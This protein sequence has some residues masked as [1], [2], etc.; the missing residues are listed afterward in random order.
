[1]LDSDHL[2]V[3]NFNEN[4][5][6][7]VLCRTNDK[8]AFIQKGLSK[9]IKKI[10]ADI[11]SVD[12]V[13]ISI[14]DASIIGSLLSMNSRGAVVCDFIDSDSTKTIEKQGLDLCIIDDKI[15]AAGNDILVNDNGCMVHP[16]LKDSTLKKIEKV[17]DVPVVRGTIGSL[18][19]VGMCAAVTNK[20]LLCHPKASAE[21]I[22]KLEKL[23]QVPV[24]I[25]TV[26]HGSPVIGSGVI[27]NVNG[28]VVGNKTTGIELG[29]IE[30]AFGFL[31]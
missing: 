21:E 15:N 2:Q 26:N 1:M 18:K 25:G 22:N 17:F 8:V 14:F 5:N 16:D 31:D 28:V 19:T 6:V 30:E 20:G 13:E 27:A 9:K 4:P 12:L 3:V 7:G 23:F 24:M 11:L 29:R 10:V